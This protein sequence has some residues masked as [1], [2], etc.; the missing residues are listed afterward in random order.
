LYL[1]APHATHQLDRTR[2][3]SKQSPDAIFQALGGPSV[4][5]DAIRSRYAL[6]SQVSAPVNILV[7]F[8]LS[9]KVQPLMSW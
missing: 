5:S 9:A 1:P 7:V 3:F 2:S 4:V 8:A 6:E